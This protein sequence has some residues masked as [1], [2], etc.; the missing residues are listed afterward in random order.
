MELSV[1][2]MSQFDDTKAPIKDADNVAVVI[3]QGKVIVYDT[4][5]STDVDS[6]VKYMVK[7]ITR[8]CNYDYEFVAKIKN[9]YWFK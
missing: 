4:T 7:M 5:D 8:C 1:V 3:Y 6:D 2:Y 9:V